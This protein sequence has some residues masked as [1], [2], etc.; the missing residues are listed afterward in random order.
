MHL[1]YKIHITPFLTRA[2]EWLQGTI[3]E[4]IM[5]N[6]DHYDIGRKDTDTYSYDIASSIVYHRNLT[7]KNCRA[8]I[9]RYIID[10]FVQKSEYSRGKQLNAIDIFPLFQNIYH[11]DIFYTPI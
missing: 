1:V 4:Y 11:F 2:C 7:K 10:L 6:T 3:D 9:Y 8:L 5:C